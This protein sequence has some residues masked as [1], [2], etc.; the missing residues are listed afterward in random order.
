MST[1]D[2]LP[3][4]FV[5]LLSPGWMDTRVHATFARYVGD[6]QGSAV[7]EDP[8][9]NRRVVEYSRLIHVDAPTPLEVP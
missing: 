1:V 4:E 6:F 8:E 9:G 3:G 2:Y 7:V 5:K